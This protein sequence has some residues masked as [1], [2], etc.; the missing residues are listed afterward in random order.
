MDGGW[1]KTDSRQP[2]RCSQP[3]VFTM[4]NEIWGGPAKAPTIMRAMRITIVD[5]PAY[6]PP[7]D[8]ALCAALARTG[9]DVELVT[10]RFRHGLVPQPDGYTR[11]ECFYRFG[12]GSRA[13]KL[14]RHPL[15]MLRVARRVRRAGPGVVHF[16]WLPL[17]LVDD[18][19]VSRFP[20]PRVLTAHDL[21]RG[22]GPW[23]AARARALAELLDAVV[24]HSDEG[25]RQLVG[26]LGLPESRVRVIPHGAFDYLTRLPN[27]IPMDAGVGEL[28]GRSVVL[29][30]GLIRPYKGV[31]LLIDAFAAAPPE[32]VLLVVG[33]A[34]MPIEPLR[35]R[36]RELGIID[37]VRFVTRFITDPEIPSYFRRADLVVLPYREIEQSGVLFTALAFGR[38]LLLSAVGGF[39]EVGERHGAAWL[40][41]PGDPEALGLALRELLS[42]D[43][44]RTALAEASRRAAAGPYSWAHVADLTKGLYDSLLDEAG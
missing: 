11:N 26:E 10:S 30:F 16:Q 35:R 21:S 24:V 38:P 18:R 36:A 14:A 1:A 3:L 42:D 12:S 5:P 39:S 4:Q 2:S 43:G 15:D 19:L 13:I 22:S 17:P 25:R 40:V 41:P 32:A 9:L 29:C 20:R 33:R 34:M 6:T 44:A 28:E 23:S 31:D 8:H 7:Y 27:E 37:R